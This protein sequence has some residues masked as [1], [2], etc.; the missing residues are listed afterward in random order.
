MAKS[1]TLYLAIAV[2]AVLSFVA[3]CSLT[4][5]ANT[6]T[7]DYGTTDTIP[8]IEGSLQQN[9][10]PPVTSTEPQHFSTEQALAEYL[11]EFSDDTDHYYRLAAVPTGLEFDS[12]SS[13]YSY[14]DWWYYIPEVSAQARI[15]YLRWHFLGNGQEWLDNDLNGNGAGR[16]ELQIGEITYYY[17]LVDEPDVGWP[18]LYDIIW[19]YDG[20]LF[21][22]NIPEESITTNGE[23]D[24]LLLLKYTELSKVMIE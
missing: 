6:E 4:A 17:L 21:S 1:R 3:G 15:I 7:T 11:K 22:M 13:Y 8:M 19:L 12:Y 2:V 14:V 5:D 9:P 24:E 16:T 10:Q 18:K 23:L 20:Y